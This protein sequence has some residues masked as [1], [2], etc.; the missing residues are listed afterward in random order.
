MHPSPSKTGD[1]ALCASESRPKRHSPRVEGAGRRRLGGAASGLTGMPRPPALS[2]LPGL[3]HQQGGHVLTVDGHPERQPTFT[4][5]FAQE[6][7][8]SAYET[9]RSAVQVLTPV[10]RHLV[11]GCRGG[12]FRRP[13]LGV[14]KPRT[15]EELLG[16]GVVEPVLPG[17]KGPHDR[18]SHCSR[19]GTGML[20]RR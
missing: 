8:H 18:M 20:G 2:L 7:S 9:P 13:G 14:R 10:C 17:F 16:G 5:G 11:C 19:V 15:A 12:L 1:P 4:A 3:S 6:F